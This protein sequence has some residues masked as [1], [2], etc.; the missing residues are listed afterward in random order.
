MD[1]SKTDIFLPTCSNWPSWPDIF[2]P[3]C[4]NWPSWPDIFPPTCSNWPSWPDI[5]PPT[6]SNW[7]SWPDIFPPTCSNWP[8]WPDISPSPKLIAAHYVLLGIAC[9]FAMTLVPCLIESLLCD[10]YHPRFITRDPVTRTR[11]QF[12]TLPGLGLTPS[13]VLN[14]RLCHRYLLL[15]FQTLP[16]LGL[17]PSIV[18]N[19]RLCHRY[20]LLQFQ[21][22]P[23][24]G[25]A[26]GL[27][28]VGSEFAVA[29]S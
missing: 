25:L 20:L 21:T 14:A 22:L 19:A 3:T 26:S 29:L 4:S 6:C 27:P 15:Q 28:G 12:Q 23:G 10:G 11:L 18:L 16:G 2:P 24:L 17:T 9:N 7:P 1:V 5:F 8:S 13:I